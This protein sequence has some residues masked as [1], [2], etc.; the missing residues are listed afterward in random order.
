MTHAVCACVCTV[1]YI[2]CVCCAI[3]NMFRNKIYVART[4][5]WGRYRERI[6]EPKDTFNY[7]M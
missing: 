1:V 5:Q 3:S 4:D 2:V 7:S 6:H